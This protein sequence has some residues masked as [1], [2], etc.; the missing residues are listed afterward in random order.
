ME[1]CAIVT[2]ASFGIGAATAI[3][4]ARSGIPVVAAARSAS[5]FMKREL[6]AKALTNLAPIDADMT[7]PIEIDRVFGFAEERKGPIRIVIHSVGFQHELGWFAEMEP[8]SILAEIASLVSSPAL[9]LSRAIRSM[10]STGGGVVGLVSSGAADKVT[11]GRALYGPAKAAVNRLVRTVAAECAFRAPNIGVFG[12][13]PGRVDTP[14]QRRL[15]RSAATAPSA[16]GLESFKSTVGVA[17]AEVVGSAIASLARRTPAEVN[18]G[19]FRYHP[20]GWEKLE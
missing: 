14:A 18:G 15:I 1:F 20:E 12:I 2:G 11:P 16:F 19:L 8:K 7:D 5:S 13:S 3:A 17:E 6:A 9:V 4:L 10:E